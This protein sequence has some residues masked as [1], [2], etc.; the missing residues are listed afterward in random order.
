MFIN[1]LLWYR[2]TT[3]SYMA[4]CDII[5]SYVYNNIMYYIKYKYKSQ[6]TV[7]K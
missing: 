6:D 7:I 2:H 5:M 1:Y 4:I 3:H